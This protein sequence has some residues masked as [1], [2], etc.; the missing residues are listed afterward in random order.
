MESFVEWQAK[1]LRRRLR[2]SHPILFQFIICLKSFLAIL[3]V[4]YGARGEVRLGRV[5]CLARD[6]RQRGQSFA[7]PSLA[8][9]PRKTG[10]PSPEH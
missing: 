8:A 1:P 3:T 9:P 7:G 5:R 2:D 6:R 10:G 4:G